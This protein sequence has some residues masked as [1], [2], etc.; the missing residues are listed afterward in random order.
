MC[1]KLVHF[2]VFKHLRFT[3]LKLIT[4]YGGSQTIKRTLLIEIEHFLNIADSLLGGCER[5]WGHGGG[6]III[7][8]MNPCSEFIAWS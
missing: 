5:L 2:E 4:D 7:S 6:G 8:G 1:K 3:L